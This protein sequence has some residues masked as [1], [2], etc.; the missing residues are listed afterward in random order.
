MN[1]RSIQL[2]ARTVHLDSSNPQSRSRHRHENS[3]HTQQQQPKTGTRS[4]HNKAARVFF[5]GKIAQQL[6]SSLT[7]HAPVQQAPVVGETDRGGLPFPQPAHSRLVGQQQREFA[8][9]ENRRPTAVDIV[10]N[11]IRIVQNLVQWQLRSTI[12]RQALVSAMPH[13]Q[14]SV[15]FRC[16]DPRIVQL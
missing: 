11:L 15:A 7:S 8:E 2:S 13:R 12:H 16:D 4:F 9:S 3:L 5:D 6:P 14:F 10:E 1:P